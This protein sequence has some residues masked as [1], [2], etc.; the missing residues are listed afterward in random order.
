LMMMLKGQG[1]RARFLA[2]MIVMMLDCLMLL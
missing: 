2:R 1:R